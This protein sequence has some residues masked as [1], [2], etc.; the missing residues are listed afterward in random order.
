MNAR[1]NPVRTLHIP[2]SVPVLV[3]SVDLP[4]QRVSALIEVTDRRLIKDDYSGQ[5]AHQS[6]QDN[7]KAPEANELDSRFGQQ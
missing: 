2:M 7:S 3:G 1:T 5:Q 4:R 6:A